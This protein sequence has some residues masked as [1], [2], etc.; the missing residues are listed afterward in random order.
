MPAS[1]SRAPEVVANARC[2]VITGDQHV[3]AADAAWE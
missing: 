3:T 2:E 1:A